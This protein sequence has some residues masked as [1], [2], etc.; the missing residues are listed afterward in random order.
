MNSVSGR[1]AGLSIQVETLNE[2]RVV[3]KATHPDVPLPPTL[4]L[5]PP[6]D[7][8]PARRQDAVEG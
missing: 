7:V 3:A 5:N 6:T 8:E 1:P 2:H 4:Q